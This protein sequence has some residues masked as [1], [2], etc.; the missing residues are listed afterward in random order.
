MPQ[1]DP[2]PG[3]FYRHFKNKK[4]QVLQIA[5]HSETREPY[6][7]YQALYGTFGVYIRPYEMFIS[8]VDH[9]KYPDVKDTYRFTLM[10]FCDEEETVSRQ[11]EI[12]VEQEETANPYLVA[13]MDAEDYDQK[14]EIIRKMRLE[15]TDRLIDEFAVVLDFEI[16]EGNLEDRYRQLKNCVD[17]KRK[18]E[19][20]R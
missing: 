16:P 18:F 11:E 3:E 20:G 12:Q 9:K 13:F 4:Y 19:S 1:K 5:L 17:L 8:E 6:V 10:E 15:L 7:V 14:M 2:R